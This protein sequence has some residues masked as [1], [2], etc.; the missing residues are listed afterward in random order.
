VEAHT[1]SST[2]VAIKKE[3]RMHPTTNN[4]TEDAV[5]NGMEGQNETNYLIS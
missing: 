5:W 2:V 1:R 4:D 3:E